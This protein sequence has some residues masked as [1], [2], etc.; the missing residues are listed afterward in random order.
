[1][2][3]CNAAT[4]IKGKQQKQKQIRENEMEW[5]NLIYVE[6]SQSVG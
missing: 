4:A 3:S 6:L 5:E 2:P 1:L